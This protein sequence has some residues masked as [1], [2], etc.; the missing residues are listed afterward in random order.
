MSKENPQRYRKTGT[1]LAE[2]I[3]PGEVRQIDTLEG[4]ATGEHPNY[5]VWANRPGGETWPI[6]QEFFD[7]EQGFE[8]TGEVV[9]GKKVYRKKDTADVLAYQVTDPDSEEPVHMRGLNEPYPPKLG[10]WILVPINGTK[11][12]VVAE[13]TFAKDWELR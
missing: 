8:P 2:Q 6:V 13:D 11:R 10:E 3:P 4:P 5:Q 12:R 1:V 7:G 9:D